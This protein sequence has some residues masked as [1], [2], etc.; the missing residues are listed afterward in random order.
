MSS[1][2][3]VHFLGYASSLAGAATGS[4]HG[5]ETIQHSKYLQQLMQQHDITLQWDAIFKPD[6][7]HHLTTLEQ[8]THLCAQLAAA[9][10]QLTQ[11][12]K[13]FVVIAGDHTS[14]IGTWSGV[15]HAKRAEGKIGLIWIDAHMDSHTPETSETG[16]LHGMPVACLLGHGETKLTKLC[17]DLPK[18]DPENICLIGIRSYEAGEKRLLEKLNAR[19]FYIEEV[20]QK[21]LAAVLR[22]AVAI[23]SRNTIGHGISIDIDSMDP[24]DA[25]GTGVAES[26]GLAAEE[27]CNALTLLAHDPRLLGVEIAEFDPTRDQQQKTEKIVTKLLAAVLCYP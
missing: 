24:Q 25:P 19:I 13:P 16:N 3:R 6:L 21:G 22:E 18:L 17:D 10:A 9:T 5:A 15:A 26:N 2:K 11:Q 12:K 1:S 4:E 27:L 23:V 20:Q 7:Q 8:V 14:A